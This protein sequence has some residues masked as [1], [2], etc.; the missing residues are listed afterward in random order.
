MRIILITTLFIGI[1]LSAY[2]QAEKPENEIKIDVLKAPS[3][4]ALNMLGVT[5]SSIEKPTDLTSFMVSIQNA[6]SNFS[7]FPKDYAFEIAPFLLFKRTGN[8][9]DQFNKKDFKSIFTQ[10]F[11]FSFGVSRQNKEDKTGNDSS[12]FTKAAVGI[13]FSII[14]QCWSDQ[15]KK[16]YE[17]LKTAQHALLDEFI[18]NTTSQ[19]INS[20]ENDAKLI[21]DSMML[22]NLTLTPSVDDTEGQKQKRE[23]LKRLVGRL[24]AI[25]KSLNEEKTILIMKTEEYKKVRKIA[26]EFKMERKKGGYLDFASGFVLDFPGDGFS[27]TQTSKVGCWLS[28]GYDSGNEGFTFS[29]ILRYLYQPDKIFADDAGILK[30]KNISTFDMG[31]RLSLNEAKGHFHLSSEAIYRSVLQKDLIN[32]SWRLV[33]NAAYDIGQNQQL[34][35]SFGRNFDGTITKDGNLIAALNFVKGFGASRKID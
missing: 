2:S 17:N 20:L 11:Q 7:S 10:S 35:F 30:T 27:N 21:R 13:K 25:N 23:I 3:S 6:T 28:G 34:T 31:G 33:F 5:P 12:S 24:A 29:G 18:N 32:P 8:T 15:T 26:S 19:N 16:V 14:R 22:V 4:P 9:L 1:S